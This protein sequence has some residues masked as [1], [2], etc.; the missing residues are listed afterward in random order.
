[1]L[2]TSQYYFCGQVQ[3][4][5]PTEVQA[6]VL[7]T[8]VWWSCQQLLATLLNNDELGTKVILYVCMYYNSTN[9][10]LGNLDDS[11]H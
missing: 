11:H 10:V 4:V 2:S 6:G 9:L 5:A 8:A 1:M 7:L 3:A